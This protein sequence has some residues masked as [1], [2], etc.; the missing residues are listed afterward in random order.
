MADTTPSNAIALQV[1]TPN[2]MNTMGNMLTVANGMQQVQ[3]NNIVLGERKNLQQVLSNPEK[4]NDANGNP[5]YSRMIPD[6]MKAAPTTGPEY[7][8]KIVQGHQA[9]TAAKDAVLGLE[10]NKRAY[11]GRYL[12]IGG[13]H[14]YYRI[15]A[16]FG[17]RLQGGHGNRPGGIAAHG[18]ENR[19]A[20][21]QSERR[22]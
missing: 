20:A 14:E 22:R 21:V 1:Q 10:A 13:H 12:M 2:A 15:V 8:T 11:V 19:S 9:A 16:M 6:I 7:I 5:D 3:T 18:L 17:D 4:Y